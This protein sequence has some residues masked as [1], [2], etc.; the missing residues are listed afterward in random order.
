MKYYPAL[1]QKD[2]GNQ[3]IEITLQADEYIGK[4]SLVVTDRRGNA[5]LEFNIENY[6][7]PDILA[8]TQINC[9][10]KDHPSDPN[11]LLVTLTHPETGTT[12]LFTV[13][14]EQFQYMIVSKAIIHHTHFALEDA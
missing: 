10:I 13:D 2:I 6:D 12:K 5:A 1:S 9:T 4:F 8:W 14:N 3:R 11:F 7:T